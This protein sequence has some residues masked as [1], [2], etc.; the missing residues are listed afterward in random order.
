MVCLAVKA[1]GPGTF[2]EWKALFADLMPELEVKDWYDPALNPA[3]IDYVLVWQPEPGRLAQMGNLKAILSAAAGVDHILADP[4]LPK[5]LPIIRMGGDETA[6]QMADYVRWAVFALLREAALWYGAQQ[7][8]QWA[9]KNAPPT[10]LSSA[11]RVGIMGLGNLGSFVAS[12]LVAADFTVFGWARHQKQCE[13]VTCY[14]GPEGLVPF[15]QQCDT[16]VCLLPETPETKGLITYSLLQHLRK[17]AG[18]INVGRGPV[19]V[20]A[21]LVRAL[22]DGTLHGAVLD[23]FDTEP[24]PETSPL[25]AVP[26]VLITPHVASE[27]S[28]P[29]RA[30]YVVSVIKALE[31]GESVPL[32]YNP[33]QGY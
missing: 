32:T 23:V 14:A 13:G 5:A 3:Q 28:R 27:A 29:A 22:Q 4:E 10:R 16:L 30:R 20:E 9:R 8:K 24:L 19:V 12:K 33:A 18:F 7:A 15:L 17:P 1:G 26:G 6:T 11:T 21:D 2:P 31:A 25:W